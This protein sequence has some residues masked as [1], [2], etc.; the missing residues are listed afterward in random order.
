M[1]L[2]VIRR[3]GT[4]AMMESRKGQLASRVLHVLQRNTMER[5][6]SLLWEVPQSSGGT[7]LDGDVETRLVKY[8]HVLRIYSSTGG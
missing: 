4:S 3:V 8:G 7:I 1:V 6:Y 5:S 2:S